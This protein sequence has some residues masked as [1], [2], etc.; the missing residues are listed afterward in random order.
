MQA[1][2]PDSRLLNRLKSIVGSKGWCAS[3]SAGKYFA[4][5][6]GHFRGNASIVLLPSSTQQVSQVVAACNEAQVGIIP[7]GGG[8]GGVAGHM[9]IS[10][11]LPVVLSLERMNAIRSV[12]IDDET[13]VAEAGCILASI[14]KIAEQH[15]RRF[16][17]SLASEGSCTIG[18][19]LASNAGG[20]QVLRYGNCRDLCLGIEAVMPDGSV[21]NDLKPLRKNNTGFDLRHLLIGSEGTLGIITASALKLSPLPEDS[22]TVMCVVPAPGSALKL[23]HKIRNKLG[24]TVTAFELMSGL[25]VT[26]ATKYFEA[27]RNPFDGPFEWCVVAEIEGH[28]G[29]QWSLEEVLEQ[30][31]EQGN[32][33]DAVFAESRSQ[34]EALWNLR[35]LAYEYNQ[36]E[37][38]ICSSDTSVPVSQI[39]KFIEL[40]ITAIR[41]L[42]DGLR[43][44]CYGHIGDGNIH[45]NI[46]P[47]QDVSKQAY[48]QMHPGIQETTRMII[49]ETTHQCGGS[50][51]A[52]HGI[53]RL[54][55]SELQRYADKTKLA[56]MQTIKT[57]I[58]PNGIMNPGAVFEAHG[59]PTQ[60][61]SASSEG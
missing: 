57:A 4:D 50:I 56:V 52:E 51:S 22:V 48:I 18:G 54:R 32:I 61:L 5:P 39:E 38:A 12:S 29:I 49:N 14:Q 8:T 24:E 10:G 33:V 7:F 3:D 41:Y 42:D 31:L 30:E 13:V 35:E 43:A 17:L 23:L 27:L 20:I 1:K 59:Q 2:T 6:R 34:S 58:D 9:E 37:G 28:K 21:L 55:I 44:N 36:K 60:I 45:V 15:G 26:L 46:F 53:G 40:T 16:G 47:P 25:G 11:S 19:N